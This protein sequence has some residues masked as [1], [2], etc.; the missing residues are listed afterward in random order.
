MPAPD[1]NLTP[2]RRRERIVR[3][4]ALAAAL[5]SARCAAGLTQH[6]L[7]EKA[8]L[9]RSAIARV[10]SGE[11]SISS[12]RIWDLARALGVRPSALYLIAEADEAAAETLK[13]EK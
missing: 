12:D 9:S 4:R 13:P 3:R 11:A 1:S 6:Q 8:G 7:A 10:E 2:Q 5:A